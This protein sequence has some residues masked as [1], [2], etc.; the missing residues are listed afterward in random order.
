MVIE[1]DEL[2]TRFN[3]LLTLAGRLPQGKSEDYVRRCVCEAI[4]A[5][6]A[7]RPVTI[8]TLISGIA[9]LQHE[10]E[11]GFDRQ[12]SGATGNDH[13]LTALSDLAAPML[14]PLPSAT[15]RETLGT[16]HTRGATMMITILVVGV[17]ALVVA[18]VMLARA[19]GPTRSVN[20]LL[21]ETEHPVAAPVPVAG[22]VKRAD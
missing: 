4:E 22:P 10:Q 19:S 3:H 5:E 9:K 6:G 18:A 20:Q 1:R 7:N 12:A 13:L 14:P 8:V 21:Y 11:R 2:E 15:S 16:I 17:L